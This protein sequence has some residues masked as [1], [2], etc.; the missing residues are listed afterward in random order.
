MTTATTSSGCTCCCCCIISPNEIV[1]VWSI[2]LSEQDPTFA[3]LVLD[4]GVYLMDIQ[5]PI[6]KCSR[7]VVPKIEAVK[8]GTAFLQGSFGFRIA[9]CSLLH[10]L[11]DLVL[12]LW[13]WWGRRLFYNFFT[14]NS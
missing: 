13:R 6:W 8:Q 14:F 9:D 4:Y 11:E 10:A 1:P 7:Y 2:L 3:Y 12:T 5:R